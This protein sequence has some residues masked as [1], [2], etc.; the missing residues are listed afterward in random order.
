M[1]DALTTH[2]CYNVLMT[3]PRYHLLHAPYVRLRMYTHAN[4]ENKT[5]LKIK[6]KA[7]D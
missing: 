1:E 7:N 3:D 2:V 4:E 5:F 6:K